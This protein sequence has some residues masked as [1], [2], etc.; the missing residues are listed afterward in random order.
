MVKYYNMKLK[1]K[2]LLIL[3]INV[4]ESNAQQFI[5]RGAIEFEVITNEKKKM[6]DASYLSDIKA[7]MPTFKTAYYK[8]T[9]ADNKSIYKFDHYDETKAKVP[10]FIKDGEDLN[11]WFNDFSTGITYI[12]KSIWESPFNLK[13]SIKNIQWKLSNE[14]RKIA[15]FDCRKAVGKIMDSVYVF[16]F[17]TEEIV[18]S[19]GPCTINGLPGM[20][21]GVTIPRMYTSMMATKLMVNDIKV[22]TIKPVLAKKYYTP[23]ELKSLLD[24]RFENNGNDNEESEDNKNWKHQLY[25]NLLL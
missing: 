9:F 16:A 5:T 8:Y 2:L 1:I 25:W 7:T 18:I 19:G 20:I 4:F 24:K 10:E 22:E 17:Y 11:E 3:F 15:G 6:S 23:K 14:H 13:D 12:Q 21:L